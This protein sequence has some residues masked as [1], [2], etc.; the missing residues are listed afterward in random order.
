MIWNA[1]LQPITSA[2][3]TTKFR[4][5]KLALLF[6]LLAWNTIVSSAGPRSVCLL[7]DPVHQCG[8][9]CLTALKPML[10]HIRFLEENWTKIASKQDKL[11]SQQAELLRKLI[12]FDKKIVPPKFEL[13]GSRYFYIEDEIRKNWY[14]AAETCRQ[15]GAQL[16]VIRSEEELTAL[17]AKLHKDRIYWLDINDLDKE[18]QFKSSASG[19]QTPFFKW[20]AGQPNN[21]DENQHCVDLLDGLMYDN[22]CEN[23]SYF[24]CQSDNDSLN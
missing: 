12:I 21:S 6:S 4:M 24:I 13:I 19:K 15:M 8:E 5:Y 17:K 20:R 14:S 11:E 7:E 2:S 23:L 9:F 3:W 16:A 10:D 1:T 22:K 18:G